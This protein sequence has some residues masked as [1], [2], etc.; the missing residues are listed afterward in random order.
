MDLGGHGLGVA[1]GDRDEDQFGR[2]GSAGP[3]EGG[4]GAPGGGEGGAEPVRV[5]AEQAD[6]AGGVGFGDAVRAGPV[7]VEEG[8]TLQRVGGGAARVGAERSTRVP[9]EATGTP[10][11]SATV[12]V[13]ASSPAG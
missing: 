11:V 7:E 6:R 13:T 10:V 12:R 5:G 1:P 2:V 3:G 9:T 8:V 4:D